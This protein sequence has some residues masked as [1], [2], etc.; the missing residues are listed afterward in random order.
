MEFDQ[1]IKFEWGDDPARH[2]LERHARASASRIAS[3][4]WKSATYP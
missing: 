2:R 4:S 1:V 3:D